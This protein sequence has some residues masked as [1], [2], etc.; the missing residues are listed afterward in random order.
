MYSKATQV[1]ADYFWGVVLGAL[2]CS[3]GSGNRAACPNTRHPPQ[4]S[5]QIAPYGV[6]NDGESTSQIKFL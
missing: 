1:N 2:P 5:D 4:C 3:G 6:D